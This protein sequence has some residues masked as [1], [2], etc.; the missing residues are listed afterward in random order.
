[1][2]FY[3]AFLDFISWIFNLE[4]FRLCISIIVCFCALFIVSEIARYMASSYEGGG[5]N[6]N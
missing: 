6:D 3:N 4:C 5:K 2:A 1:M